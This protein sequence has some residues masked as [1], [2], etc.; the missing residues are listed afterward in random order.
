MIVRPLG[1]DLIFCP[2]LVIDDA[3]LD[4]VVDALHAALV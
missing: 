1:E 4:R 2:P 3:G